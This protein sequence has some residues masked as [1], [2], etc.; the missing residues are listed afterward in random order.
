M[1]RKK[2]KLKLTP[3]DPEIFKDI[4]KLMKKT[5]SLYEKANRK[6]KK[7]DLEKQHRDSLEILI[8]SYRLLR[9]I[10]QLRKNREFIRKKKK[11]AIKKLKQKN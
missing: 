9:K 6:G 8:G 4:Y 7:Y 5:E 2:T 11:S 3:P 10:K 1:E